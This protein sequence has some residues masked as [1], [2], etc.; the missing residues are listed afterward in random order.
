MYT[1]I[2]IVKY[3]AFVFGR[4]LAPCFIELSLFYCK[5]Y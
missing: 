5:M 4:F 2:V 3:F 1:Y